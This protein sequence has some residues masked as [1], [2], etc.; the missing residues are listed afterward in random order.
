VSGIERLT[1]TNAI[2]R[3]GSALLVATLVS[4]G[5]GSDQHGTVEIVAGS[6]AAALNFRIVTDGSAEELVS[7]RV[8]QLVAGEPAALAHWYLVPADARATV[9]PPPVIRYGETPLGF[10]SWQP[11]WLGPGKYEIDVRLANRRIIHRFEVSRDGSISD[12]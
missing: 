7:V 3:S 12:L 9:A 2:A 1:V 11:N 4:F 5:C 6:T 8:V 10:S